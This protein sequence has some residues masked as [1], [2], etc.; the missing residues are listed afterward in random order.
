M[1]Q[2]CLYILLVCVGQHAELLAGSY[3]CWWCPSP[4]LLKNRLQKDKNSELKQTLHVSFHCFSSH[5][6]N[7]FVGPEAGGRL[8]FLSLNDASMQFCCL[9]LSLEEMIQEQWC[10]AFTSFGV[11]LTCKWQCSADCLKV[12]C[13]VWSLHMIC[14]FHH[15]GLVLRTS[16]PWVVKSQHMQSILQ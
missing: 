7:M 6:K 16:I 13:S 14:S 12:M 4:S 10:V 3:S 5:F 1:L 9:S 11:S 15:V 2:L 8:S